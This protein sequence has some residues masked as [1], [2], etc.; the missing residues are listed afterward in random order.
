MCSEGG[1]LGRLVLKLK[2][3]SL[4][5]TAPPAGRRIPPKSGSLGSPG[6][7]SRAPSFLG[8][9]VTSAGNGSVSTACGFSESTESTCDASSQQLPDSSVLGSA[10]WGLLCFPRTLGL[11]I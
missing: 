4:C 1:E 7:L 5:D 3:T 8:I 6:V 11:R 9:R 2:T 10:Q